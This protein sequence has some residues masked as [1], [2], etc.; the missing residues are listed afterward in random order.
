MFL[1][2]LAA[3]LLVYAVI[4]FF[5][6]FAKVPWMMKMARSKLGEGANDRRVVRFMNVSGL[7][8]F[9]AGLVVSYL[10]FG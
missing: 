9:V 3:F 5:S 7:G 1:K 2:L 6:A 10:A 8:L 4:L